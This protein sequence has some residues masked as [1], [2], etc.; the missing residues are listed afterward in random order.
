MT[1]RLKF[2]HQRQ[3]QM[4]CQTIRK[5]QYDPW[6][7]AVVLGFRF[8]RLENK[9]QQHHKATFIGSDTI[10]RLW[11]TFRE[12]RDLR[13][14]IEKNNKSNKLQNGSQQSMVQISYADA[15]TKASRLPG[16]MGTC[17]NQCSKTGGWMVTGVA[18]RCRC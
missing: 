3:N 15:C 10:L 2:L 1:L 18:W 8:L 13:N 16:L 6:T 7:F 12:Q 9:R 11:M 5:M 17:S 4:L 14:A